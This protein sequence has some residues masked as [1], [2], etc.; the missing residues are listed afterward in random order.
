M[1]S[2][3]ITPTINN[4]ECSTAI[5]AR[6]Q[7]NED[8]IPSLLNGELPASLKFTYPMPLRSCNPDQIA[9]IAKSIEKINSK[10]ID[11]LYSLATA[12]LLTPEGLLRCQET[13]VRN[14]AVYEEFG[15]VQRINFSLPFEQA[16]NRISDY[17]TIKKKLTQIANEERINYEARNAKVG[18]AT[19]QPYCSNQTI[20]FRDRQEEITRDILNK[21]Y[22]RRTDSD[23]MI[24]L[25]D[26]A[27]SQ[28]LRRFKHLFHISKNIQSIADDAGFT[29]YFV[30]L[31]APGNYH[32]NP[33]NGKRSYDQNNLRNAHTYIQERWKLIRARLTKVGTPLSIDTF[34]GM[35]TVEAH[36]DGCAHWHLMIFTRPE[37]FEIFSSLVREFFPR[38]KQCDF[39]TID[40]EKGEAT[41][42]LFKYLTKAV[43]SSKFD[44]KGL[45]QDDRDAELYLLDQSTLTHARRVTTAL[46]AQRIRQYQCFGIGNAMTKYRV[47]NKIEE[48][49][50]SI[51]SEL[52]KNT[53]SAC[54]VYNNGTRDKGNRNL[55]GFKNLVTKFN[56]E[57]ELIKEPYQNRFGEPAKRI[58]GV[59]FKC[60]HAVY[61]PVYE[62][63]RNPLELLEESIVVPAINIEELDDLERKSFIKDLYVANDDDINMLFFKERGS[64]VTVIDS[65]P[66]EANRP[67]RAKHKRPTASELLQTLNEANLK[68]SNVSYVDINRSKTVGPPLEVDEILALLSNW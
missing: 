61:L 7:Y 63:Y 40:R 45:E 23:Q 11:N 35:R 4:K 9:G 55:I 14:L 37:T 1:K 8:V 10:Q 66:R 26:I 12:G 68:R 18:G 6:P 64:T 17:R 3:K 52:A 42:Y 30:T 31:T 33:A 47:I 29:G 13:L 50:S 24:T 44:H 28:E 5:A 51:E 21:I 19:N 54:R 15:E 38:L 57:F 56:E 58:A 67:C 65:D 2:I 59:R 48:S 53:L 49:I 16:L 34:F 39:K 41:S 60:G 46:R 36:K 22:V 20:I 43:D 62:I 32:P 25:A 27:E